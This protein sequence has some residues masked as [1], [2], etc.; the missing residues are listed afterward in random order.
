[1]VKGRPEPTAIYDARALALSGLSLEVLHEYIQQLPRAPLERQLST[2]N[3]VRYLVCVY[4]IGSV[5]AIREICS[6]FQLAWFAGQFLAAST[7]ARMMIELWGSIVYAERKVL[8]LI[9]DGDPLAANARMVKLVFGSKSGVRLHKDLPVTETPV[10]VMEFVRAAESVT[11]GT[12]DDYAFLCD[13]AH[14]S[15]LQ[16]SY[17]LFAGAIYDNWTNEAFA[18]QMHITLDRTLRIGANV[19]EG[20]E[21]AAVDVFKRCLVSILEDFNSAPIPK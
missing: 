17:L 7:L 4:V 10:N 2:A 20:I 16:N 15:Y 18:K 9:E 14:P 8:V 11:P 21:T 1:M 5:R 3:S 19:L 13:A 12:E 6:T